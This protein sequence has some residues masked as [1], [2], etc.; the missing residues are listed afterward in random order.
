MDLSKEELEEEIVAL[1]AVINA[2]SEQS[3][4]NLKG[5]KINTIILKHF[6]EKLESFK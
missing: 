3:K 6:E 2:H 5:V 4:L 1:K